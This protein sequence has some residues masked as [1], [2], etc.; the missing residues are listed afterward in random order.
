M[1][2]D[3]EINDH[4]TFSPKNNAYKLC[5]PNKKP[6]PPKHFPVYVLLPIR[7]L[8]KTKNL[9]G[10]FPS[11]LL[12]LLLHGIHGSN[13]G[14]EPGAQTKLEIDLGSLY[15][16]VLFTV[17]FVSCY[18]SWKSFSQ[19]LCGFVPVHINA[20]KLCTCL[21]SPNSAK[22]PWSV[23]FSNLQRICLHCI[24]IA[25]VIWCTPAKELLP[26]GHY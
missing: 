20:F 8:W 7:K 19:T 14:L 3:Q 16:C 23:K 24:V 5:A 26:F 4:I 25:L 9:T 1:E 12:L 13:G 17:F 11:F 22:L 18:L 6:R 2:D 10:A 15:F 21:T